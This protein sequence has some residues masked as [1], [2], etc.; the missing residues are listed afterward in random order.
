MHVELQQ[1]YDATDNLVNQ[2][3]YFPGSDTII[4]R[5]PEISIKIRNSGQI[6]QKFKD[7]FMRNIDFFLS[8]DY[9]KFLLSFKM[10]KGLDEE[11][12]KKINEELNQ[13]IHYL[14][15]DV[16]DFDTIIKYTIVLNA[17]ISYIRNVH[18]NNAIEEV[19]KRIRMR[20][21]RI[22]DN[23]IQEE[24]DKLFMRNNQNVSILYNIAYLDALA[25]S[26]GFKKVAH[27]CKVQ[28]GKFINRIVNLIISSNN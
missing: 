9:F 1:L 2:Q 21:S 18:F 26:F 25:E 8:S 28:K 14:Q 12:I 10:I 7:V 13:K 6:I 24:M 19:N 16:D 5:T 11:K 3:F 4:G 15:E 27:V 23:K 20:S 22:S 17:I